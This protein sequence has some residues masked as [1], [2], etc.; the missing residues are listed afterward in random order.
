MHPIAAVEVE[1]S[2][3]ETDILTNG[4]TATCAELGIPIVAY[5]PLG[6]GVLAG[7]IKQRADIPEGDI[8]HL[9]SRFQED[10]LAVNVKFYDQVKSLADRKNMTPAQLAL[11][12]IK[13][14]SASP[15]M[16]TIIPIPGSSG[17]ER[18][19]ENLKD[20]PLFSQV[21]MEEIDDIVKGRQIVG[22]RY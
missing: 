5:S 11:T 14:L 6:R 12:W 1:L 9:L 15:G 4:V 21:E 10:T 7:R 20:L 8:R 19:L 22:G 16:P 18:I 2:L 17:K 3:W 13:S